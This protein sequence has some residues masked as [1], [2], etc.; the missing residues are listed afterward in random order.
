MGAAPGVAG[1]TTRE[2]EGCFLCLDESE[3]DWFI[4]LNNTGGAVDVWVVDGVTIG[5]LLE[6]PTGFFYVPRAVAPEHVK[7][8]RSDRLDPPL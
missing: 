5:D 1:T 3:A 2:V 7:L 4:H 6:S 8:A